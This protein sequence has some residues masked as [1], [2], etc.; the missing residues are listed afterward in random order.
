VVCGKYQ[1]TTELIAGLYSKICKN[2]YPTKNIKTAEAA[3]IIENTQRDLNIALCNEL[4]M[5]FALLNIDTNEVLDAAATK[6]NFARY[7]PGMV[8]GHCIPVDPYYLV[9]KARELG[10]HSQVIL[11][12][13]SINDNMPSY[14]ALK[15]IKMINERSRVIKGSKVLIMG[16]TYKENVSD[17][18]ETPSK[19][20]IRELED[21][22]V[23]IYAYD[24]W[25]KNIGDDFGVKNVQEIRQFG[26]FDCVIITVKHNEFLEYKLEDLKSIMKPGPILVDVRGLYRR[27][28]AENQGFLY[29][30]L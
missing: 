7:Y 18:R 11:A 8:G 2:V 16:L 21:Y 22:G 27:E 4:S 3:K 26:D 5:I 13:R 30:T 19:E 15:A 6:W 25:V 10:Y 17:I 9:Y 1:E 23:D 14:V 12:G 24:P 29:F 20:I 28:E